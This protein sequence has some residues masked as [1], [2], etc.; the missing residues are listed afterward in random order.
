ME[1]LDVI[2]TTNACRY[3]T[4]DAVPDALLLQV[5][6]A[7]RW[8]PTGSNKQPVTFLAVRDAAKR[9]ALHDRLRNAADEQH[10][11]KRDDERLELEAR[12]EQPLRETDQ[13]RHRERHGDSE[14]QTVAEAAGFV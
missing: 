8:A 4:P 11:A 3:Y 12:D 13:Q 2:R 1:L 7:A 5:L 6:D 10:A 14:R 9:R